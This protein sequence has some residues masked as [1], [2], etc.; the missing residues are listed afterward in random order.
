MDSETGSPADSEFSSSTLRATL[1]SIDGASNYADWVVSFADPY[2]GGRV[3][4]VGAGVG[5]LTPR[6]LQG[7]PGRT[8]DA[9]EPDPVLAAHLAERMA[10][11]PRVVVERRPVE[12]LPDTDAFDSA[13]FINV[14]EHIDDHLGALRATHRV[15]GPGGHLYV[16]SPA[17]TFL[18]S[19]FDR[20]IG[21][22]RRYRRAGLEA[23]VRQAGFDVVDSRYVNLPGWF[24]WLL[25]A[26]VLGKDPTTS[27]LAGLYDRRFVPLA[28]RV[29]RA[30][31]APFGQSVLVV[32]RRR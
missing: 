13:V 27:D 30:V 4:E 26:R 31:R 19:D 25:V 14:L 32:A 11:N 15:L 3:L 5:T 22:C 28:R 21:H 12:D 6:L 18:M 24:A 29:E 17:F 20:S 8:V 7:D 23:I 16:Y 2:L 9:C 1:D 10:G